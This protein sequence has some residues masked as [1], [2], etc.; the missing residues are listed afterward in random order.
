MAFSSGPMQ[1]HGR[2]TC[3]GASNYKVMTSAL[4]PCKS[5]LKNCEWGS[6]FYSVR[7]TLAPVTLC[8]LVPAWAFPKGEPVLFV[9]IREDFIIDQSFSGNR[10]PLG[11]I[12][13]R[14]CARVWVC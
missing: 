6:S 3:D 10:G 8:A 12:I 2:R 13:A 14:S 11:I 4:G 9:I 5:R 1:F 7:W